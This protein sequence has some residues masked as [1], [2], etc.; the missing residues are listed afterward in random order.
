MPLKFEPIG[1]EHQTAYR[2]LLDQCPPQAS[3]YS[4]I[5]LWGWSEAYGLSWAWQDTLVWIRQ[6]RP[7][8]SY[9][10]PVGDWIGTDWE[11]VL[12]ANFPRGTVFIRVPERLV[13]LW[14]SVQGERLQVA[15]TRGQWD[16]LYSKADLVGLKGNRYHK[17]KNLL[18][19]FVKNY[20]H[21][22]APLTADSV[23]QALALQDAWCTWRDCESS[24]TLAAENRV[25]ARILKAW[26]RLE[27]VL[28][29]GLWVKE[30]LV[31]YTVA[32]ALDPNTLLIHFEKGDAG[33]KGV[34]QAISQL[35]LADQGDRFTTVNRE[36]DLD[37]AG[38]RQAK[39]SY[40]PTNFLRKYEILLQ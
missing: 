5:N 29:G 9:W 6:S 19:Q 4:F 15:E 17:K 14:Q 39:L 23:G 22:Y 13:N 31:A 25:I 18:N 37:D 3:D 38:L 33:F 26:G 24:A 12:S 30:A 8:V 16:Y 21:V 1:L 2:R 32:E 34:Y 20:P 35:F 10:A 27:G 28:A 40:H 7:T 11:K 36:Q